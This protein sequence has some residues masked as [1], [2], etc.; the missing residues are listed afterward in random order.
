M[1]VLSTNLGFPRMGSSREL[2]GLLE[3]YWAGEESAVE[4]EAGAA[5]LR[6]FHWRLQAGLGI[7]HVRVQPTQLY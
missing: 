7:D 1:V 6:A 4:L 2:K 5:E 3:S